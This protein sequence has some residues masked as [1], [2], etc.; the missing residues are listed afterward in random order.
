MYN[1]FDNLLPD[2]REIRER[3]V[4]RF[5]ANSTEPFDILAQVGRDC[6]GAT[7]L[8]PADTELPDFRRIDAK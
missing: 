3:M 8:L 5:K 4:A 2:S 7:Q 1:F 6:V